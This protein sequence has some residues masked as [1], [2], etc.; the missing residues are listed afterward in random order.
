MRLLRTPLSRVARWRDPEREEVFVCG[1]VIAALRKTRSISFAINVSVGIRLIYH[2][3]Q[4]TVGVAS[5]I[6]L[7]LIFAYWYARTGRLWPAVIAHAII[8]F[9]GLVIYVQP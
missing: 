6:P 2:L 4:G 7:G 3:Y 5:I 1:Y 8:D 9:A